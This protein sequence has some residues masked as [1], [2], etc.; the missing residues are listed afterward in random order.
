MKESVTAIMVCILIVVILYILLFYE[1]EKPY[2]A[3]LTNIHTNEVIITSELTSTLFDNKY[4]IILE[5]GSRISVNKKD[6]TILKKWE[7]E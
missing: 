5:D 4:I 6:F 2:T 7:E 1:P 3:T